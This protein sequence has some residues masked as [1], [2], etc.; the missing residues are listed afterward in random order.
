LVPEY[1]ERKTSYHPVE[2][3]NTAATATFRKR[4][5]QFFLVLFIGDRY[6][7]YYAE[8][9]FQ[10]VIHADLL[11]LLLHHTRYPA[12]VQSLHASGGGAIQDFEVYGE[13]LRHVSG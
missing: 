9:Y 6:A 4:D 2:T 12:I 1:Y 7:M 13:Y 11:F 10:I 5:V 8:C 3:D